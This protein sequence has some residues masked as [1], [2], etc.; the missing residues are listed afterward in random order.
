MFCLP[1]GVFTSKADCLTFAEEEL[2]D[3]ATKK[4]QELLADT[5]ECRQ[6]IFLNDVDHVT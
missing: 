4:G 3:V 6:S 5:S 1:Y 2:M